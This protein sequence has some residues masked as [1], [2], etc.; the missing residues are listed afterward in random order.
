MNISKKA[1]EVFTENP[2]GKPLEQCFDDFHCKTILYHYN[3]AYTLKQSVSYLDHHC[4]KGATFV[5]E[6]S[7]IPI[8]DEDNVYILATTKEVI[9]TKELQE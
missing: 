7:V 8:F 3:R 9:K 6:T 5:N 2:R 1:E 4:V